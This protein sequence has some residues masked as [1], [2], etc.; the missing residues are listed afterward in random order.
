MKIY[1]HAAVIMVFCSGCVAYEWLVSGGLFGQ[2]K[3]S[4]A[5]QHQ[6]KSCSFPMFIHLVTCSSDFGEMSVSLASDGRWVF[7][8]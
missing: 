8:S 6:L 5:L 3:Y 2:T 7:T 1:L 4:D